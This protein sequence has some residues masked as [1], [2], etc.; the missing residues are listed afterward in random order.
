MPQER[1]LY[2]STNGQSP[3]VDFKTAM[4]Y[5]DP[6]DN[7]L[8]VPTRVPRLD[9]SL[10][11]EF[12][13]MSYSE[14]VYHVLRPWFT[15]EI[16]DRELES[17]INRTYTW[18]VPVNE[19]GDDFYEDLTKGP[20]IAFKCFGSH[21]NAMFIEYYHHPE[22][23]GDILDILSTSGDTGGSV[24]KALQRKPNILVFVFF[25]IDDVTVFQRRQMTTLGYNIYAI[26]VRSDFDGC[27]AIREYCL[28]NEDP[29]L[30]KYMRTTGNSKSLGRFLPQIP[31]HF[32][33]AAKV[34]E[35]TGADRVNLWIPFGN[36]GNFN[37]AQYA[38]LMGAPIHIL[39]AISNE[40]DVFPNFINTGV[41]SPE[42]SKKCPSEAMDVGNPSNMQRIAYL[43]GGCIDRDGVVH[44]M[45]DLGSMRKEIRST[46]ISNGRTREAI[47]YAHDNHGVVLDPH[48]A[49]A[50][51]GML[52]FKGKDDPE[53]N[54]YPNCFDETAAPVK[55]PDLIREELG[56]E[57]ELPDHMKN[58]YELEERMWVID[59][60][61]KQ[62]RDLILD[63]VKSRK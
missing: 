35:E 14:V 16:P 8:Y 51:A 34:R 17:M 63:I 42:K 46:S 15:E 41:Y 27:Q 18:P 32:Y 44:K 53:V 38:K 20:A 31:Y 48:G 30:S 23:D 40:N 60:D 26:G 50:Y 37:S 22:T 62:A 2:K 36:A 1:I 19:I 45:P 47:R 56:I 52:E 13:K 28:G 7:G 58:I 39:G 54:M 55:F 21:G 5:P 43:A 24:S 49:V 12:G 61:K 3:L 33:A 9:D 4:F 57:P 59:P 25:P 10:V 29:E 11:R 6:P